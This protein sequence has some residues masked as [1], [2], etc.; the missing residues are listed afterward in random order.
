MKREEERGSSTLDMADMWWRG[1]W[2]G[3]EGREARR[4]LGEGRSGQR[5][6]SSEV[7]G[8]GDGGH[9]AAR[10]VGRRLRWR[11]E[12]DEEA[13]R[14]GVRQ[15]KGE[16]GVV[17]MG[18]GGLVVTREVG[19]KPRQWWWEA[20]RQPGKGAAGG[21]G[22]GTRVAGVGH[23]GLVVARELGRQPRRRGGR[24]GGGRGRGAVG[25]GGGARVV[26]ASHGGLVVAREVGRQP[27]QLGDGGEEATTANDCGS[28]N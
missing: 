20:R 18:H 10:K 3:D 8:V 15:V 4:R 9:V 26:D 27:R 5:G 16:A 6:S 14:G 17:G 7:T 1:R 25:R 13:A 28:S 21:G 2:G 11:G 12:G 24:R 23:G 19:R 22:G